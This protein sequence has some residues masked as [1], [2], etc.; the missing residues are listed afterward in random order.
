MKAMVIRIK[1]NAQLNRS[2]TVLSTNVPVNHVQYAYKDNILRI[3]LLSRLKR[4]NKIH[5][6]KCR[7]TTGNTSS[8]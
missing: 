6:Y 1:V 5:G 2:K 4:G 8:Y 3:T 7:Y